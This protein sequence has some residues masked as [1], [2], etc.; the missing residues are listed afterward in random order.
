MHWSSRCKD[1]VAPGILVGQGKNCHWLM[2]KMK[3]AD[4]DALPPDYERELR[5]EF[6][7]T[8]AGNELDA[9]LRNISGKVLADLFSF[10]RWPEGNIVHR[11]KYDPSRHEIHCAIDFGLNHPHI[12]WISHDPTVLDPSVTPLDVVVDEFSLDGPN[13]DQVMA[14]L[15]QQEAVWGRPYS[16]FYPDPSSTSKH[17]RRV[18]ATEFPHVQQRRYSKASY[19]DTHWGI[20]V[21]RSRLKNA[22]GGRRLAFSSDLLELPG[23]RSPEGRGILNCLANY[24]YER[25][26][27]GRPKER[28]RDDNW[29]THGIDALRYYVTH[30]Y[31]GRGDSPS[32]V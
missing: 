11:F 13:L 20:H 18:L 15:H 27:D 17:E 9:E 24:D 12:L 31:P 32:F 8:Q 5:R 16:Y 6:D 23:N 28:F 25:G 1:E 26:R 10:E 22:L 14:V 7:E 2:C 19:L 29:Y 3:T 4:N 30:M 21:L